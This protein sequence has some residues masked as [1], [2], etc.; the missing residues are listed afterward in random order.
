MLVPAGYIASNSLEHILET[1]PLVFIMTF[2]LIGS[3]ITNKLIVSEQRNL[4]WF[5]VKRGFVMCYIARSLMFN[6]LTSCTTGRSNDQKRITLCRS[7]IFG[8]FGNVY[9]PVERSVCV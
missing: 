7:D 4:I 6:A 3:K 9:K 1:K 2:G 8:S 5:A